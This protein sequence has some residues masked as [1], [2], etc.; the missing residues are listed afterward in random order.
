MQDFIQKAGYKAAFIGS[1]I[2]TFVLWAIPFG[3]GDLVNYPFKIFTTLI[4]ELCHA[5][6][7]LLTGGSIEGVRLNLDGSGAT[8]HRGGWMPLIASAGYVGTTA[9]G[10]ALLTLLQRGMPSQWLLNGLRAATVAVAVFSV[11]FS[12]ATFLICVGF[13][14]AYTLVGWWE[15]SFADMSRYVL[16]TYVGVQLVSNSL[17]DFMSLIRLSAGTTAH[18]D[19]VNMAAAVGGNSIM[20][21]FTWAAMSLGLCWIYLKR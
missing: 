19:A 16:I 21:A 10:L 5:I 18:T 7:A 14:F 3:L 12:P 15:N 6:A 1:V 4:H 17:L 8:L 13:L 11:L 2:V 9:A 20:W